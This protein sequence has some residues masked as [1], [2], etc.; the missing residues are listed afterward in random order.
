MKLVFT[1]DI[2]AM[3]GKSW[4]ERVTLYHLAR[5]RDKRIV[6]RTLAVHILSF[7]WLLVLMMMRKREILPSLAWVDLIYVAMSAAIG[8]FAHGL[9]INPLVKDALRGAAIDARDTDG[10]KLPEFDY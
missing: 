10:R 4:R 5:T 2:P 3:Q 7:P 9:W 6:L 1:R 8:L